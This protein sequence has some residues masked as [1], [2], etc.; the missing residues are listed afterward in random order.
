MEVRAMTEG[1]I[2][3]GVSRRQ[4]LIG[5]GAV[6]G[7]AA[8]TAVTPSALAATPT[9]RPEDFD[10]AVATAWFDLALTLVRTTPGFSPPVAARAL[11]YAGV[12]VY[13][14]VVRGSREYESLDRVLPGLW[15]L[16]GG[17]RNLHWPAVANAGLSRVLGWLFATT[18]A[19][20]QHAI[21]ALESSFADRFRAE[22]SR[23][24]F[25]ASVDRGREVARTVFDWSRSDG[26]HDGYLRNFPPTY[27]PPIGPGL[28]VPTPPAFQ[29]ALQPTWGANRCLAITDGTTCPP[30][31]H[32][33]F[34]EDA[35]SAF[36]AEAVEVYD[37]VNDRTPEQEAVARFW[38][39]DPGA[40]STPPGHSVSVATQILRR[41]DASLMAAAEVYAK[42][43]I[44]VADAFV[45]C[46]NTKYRYNLLRP[47]TFI[48]RLIDPE[49][50]PL[51]VTPPF[52]EYTSGHSVQSGAAFTVLADVFGDDHAF[53]DHT[54]DHLGLAPRRFGS[55][56]EAASEAAISRLYGGIHYRPAIE[57]GLEQGR[58]IADA[59]SSLPFRG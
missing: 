27:V 14:A 56:S 51:L 35:A 49:W 3:G 25:R 32:T 42:V 50:S 9:N 4:F 31:D 43:G 17:R 20:N 7:A 23:R 34:S 8:V 38:S 19:P 41:E 33:P 11:A 28:W 6:G 24:E 13:E 44:A 55:F 53:E 18:T 21:D 30:G 39:D 57:R 12:T 58:C 1:P 2:G 54:H 40:T 16:P 15:G 26:G 52:P 22:L 59:V 29:S 47:V 5:V 36:Y 48:Q 37:A 46:W 10:A 45:A